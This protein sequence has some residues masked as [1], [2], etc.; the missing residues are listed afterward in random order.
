MQKRER[1]PQMKIVIQGKTP[2]V[3]HLYITNKW[4]KR[5][6]SGLN[7][8]IKAEIEDTTMTQSTKQNYNQPDW[9]G[10]LL[11]VTTTIHENWYNKDHTIKKK[12][13]VN[14]EKFLIDSV[15]GGL[16]LDDSQIWQHIMN[17]EVE[18]DPEKFRAEI[19]IGFYKP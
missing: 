17:K 11:K 6:M 5:I 8:K 14:R 2:T 13:I 4:G 3:N 16:R 18:E 1:D 9:Q 10:R 7:R 12:D 19:E 15:M